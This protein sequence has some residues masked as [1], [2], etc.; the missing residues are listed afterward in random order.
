VLIVLH[1]VALRLGWSRELHLLKIEAH[2]L[3][4]EYARRLDRMRSGDTV[5]LD[6]IE[7]GSID[8]PTPAKKKAA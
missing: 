7:V 6:P 8:E 2:R 5:D 1:V 3:R 4:A